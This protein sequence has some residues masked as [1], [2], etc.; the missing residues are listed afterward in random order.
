MN[1]VHSKECRST[2]DQR[3][4]KPKVRLNPFFTK[5]SSLIHVSAKTRHPNLEK[6]SIVPLMRIAE[7]LIDNSEYI[8]LK[9]ARSFFQTSRFFRQLQRDYLNTRTPAQ[10]AAIAN[11]LFSCSK[12]DQKQKRLPEKGGE[13]FT[14]LPQSLQ[15]LVPHASALDYS[16][17]QEDSLSQKF[18]QLF[19]HSAPFSLTKNLAYFSKVQTLNI[20]NVALDPKDIA[21]LPSLPHLHTLSIDCAYIGNSELP[22][23]FPSL[24]HMITCRTED[25]ST[26]PLTRPKLLKLVQQYPKLKTLILPPTQANDRYLQTV[27]RLSQLEILTWRAPQCTDSGIRAL[28]TLQNLKALLIEAQITL[29]GVFS[30]S[31][32]SNL[33]ILIVNNVVSYHLLDDKFFQDIE[34]LTNLK[35]LAIKGGNFSSAIIKSLKKLPN[36]KFL[37]IITHEFDLEISAEEIELFKQQLIKELPHIQISLNEKGTHALIY[38]H[39]NTYVKAYLRA[40]MDPE[41]L[42]TSTE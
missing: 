4:V 36:L 1:P 38:Q 15:A 24:K 23:K 13:L 42:D 19:V 25:S 22:S 21:Q 20:L 29:L 32:L 33:E 8:S 6:L 17:T 10:K 2:E 9:D 40:Q 35:M 41:E 5:N 31:T 34:Q 37:Y 14:I 18:R 26:H 27:S 28:K 12:I 30:L 3:K 7:F 16:S 39:F 11:S